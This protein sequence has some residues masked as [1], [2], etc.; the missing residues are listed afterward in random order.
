MDQVPNMLGCT[1]ARSSGVVDGHMPDY[2]D[3]NSETSAKGEQKIVGVHARGVVVV[4]KVVPA[5]GADLEGGT[6]G[7]VQ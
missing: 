7:L 5:P 2:S 1:D 4:W 6:E 3:S